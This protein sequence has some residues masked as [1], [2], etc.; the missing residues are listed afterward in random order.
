MAITYRR[1]LMK[2]M[3]FLVESRLT[4]LHLT[5]AD[6]RYAAMKKQIRAYFLKAL[7]NSR[8]E[9]IFALDGEKV[10]GT[11][12]VF[13]YDSVP[14][15]Y[16]P[17]GRNAYITSMYVQED[18]RRQGIASKILKKLMRLAMKKGCRV[19]FLSATEMGR[20]LYEKVGFTDTRGTMT[21]KL[22]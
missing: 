16:I 11:G 2:D 17:N 4:F 21:L 13:Y 3:D 19:F 12:L 6:E 15:L 1:A 5:P 7:K 18:Y 22:T 10:V 14:S 8:C 20:P 9:A